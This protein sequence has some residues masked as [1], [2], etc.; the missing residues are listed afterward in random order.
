MQ[1][2]T[3]EIATIK[4]AVLL[5]EWAEQ[6]EAQQSSRLSVKKWCEENGIK[7]NTYYCWLKRVREQFICH[8]HQEENI[9]PVNTTNYGRECIQQRF[10]RR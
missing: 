9:Y 2:K 8:P 5:H 3:K 1:E 10:P 4:Q 6:T 7:P